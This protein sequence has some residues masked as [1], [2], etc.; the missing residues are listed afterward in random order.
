MAPPSVRTQPACG[1]LEGEGRGDEYP[2]PSILFPAGASVRG[3]VD[4]SAG[5]VGAQSA[6]ESGS[7]GH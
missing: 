7:G 5:G 3:Q 6:V 2:S 4:A 1:G